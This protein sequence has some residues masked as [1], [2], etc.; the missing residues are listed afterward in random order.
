MPQ[1]GGPC[2]QLCAPQHLLWR[3]W[4]PWGCFSR[5]SHSVIIFS[6]LP[7]GRHNSFWIFILSVAVRRLKF[8]PLW[9]TGRL[10]RLFVPIVWNQW[11]VERLSCLKKI[12]FFVCFW[13]VPSLTE[14]RPRS[15]IN[16]MFPPS[17]CFLFPGDVGEFLMKIHLAFAVGQVQVLQIRLFAFLSTYVRLY[18][19][20]LLMFWVQWC[21]CFCLCNTKHFLSAVVW[22]SHRVLLMCVSAMQ[23]EKEIQFMS[24]TSRYK[25]KWGNLQRV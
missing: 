10:I 1:Q 7:L 3:I 24:V 14:Y 9:V 12:P 2:Q 11:E 22:G 25:R 23:G 15:M 21:V 4:Q 16:D 19:E 18:L 5:A 6:L 13:L 20:L 17:F 8:A